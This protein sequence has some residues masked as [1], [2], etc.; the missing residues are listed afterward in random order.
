[1]RRGPPSHPYHLGTRSRLPADG[2]RQWGVAIHDLEGRNVVTAARRLKENKELHAGV[3][4]AGEE[5]AALKS[6]LLFPR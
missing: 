5:A 2:L 3:S 6:Y 4:A 1:M